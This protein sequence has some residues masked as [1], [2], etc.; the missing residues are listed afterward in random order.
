MP[1]YLLAVWYDAL[2]RFLVYTN[3]PQSDAIDW[4]VILFVFLGVAA[5]I[6][7]VRR[8]I[9]LQREVVARRKAQAEAH[10]MARHDVLTGLPNRRRF[11]EDFNGSVEHLPPGAACAMFV[12]DLDNF[13]PINDV[14]GHRLGDEVLKVISRRLTELAGGASVARLGGDEFGVTLQYQVGSDAPERLARQIVHELS[15]PIQLAALSLQVGASVGVATCDKRGSGDTDLAGMSVR[16]NGAV[17]T[18]LRRADMAMYWAKADGRGRYRFFDRSMD[19]KLRQ[20]VELELQIGGA[21]TLGQIV[22]YYQ[23]IV[24]LETG[25]TIG[26]EVLARWV[27][28]RRGVLTSDVFIAIAEDTGTI[29]KMTDLLIERAM[30]DAKDWPEHLSVSVNFSPRQISDPNVATRILGLL[31]KVGFP[32]HR[33]VMEITE[34]AVVQKLEAAKA[35]LQSLRNVGVRIALD[36][37]GTGYSGLYHLRE[38]ELDIVKIDRSFVGEIL[39][40]PEE[41]RIVKAMLSLGHALG[42]TTTAEGIE[43]EEV[44]QYLL[45]LGCDAGQGYL[46]GA[47]EPAAMVTSASQGGHSRPPHRLA[48]REHHHHLPAFEPRLRFHLG[49]SRG[50]L[51]DPLEQLG[52]ELHMRHLAAPEAQGDFHLVALLEEP[53]DR[54]HLHLVVVDVDVRPHLDLLDLDGALLLARLGGLFLRL[55]FVLAVIQDLAHRRL[56]IGRDLDQIEPGFNRARQGFGRGN[57]ADIVAGSVDE[58]D[59]GNVDALV[60]AR[61]ALFGGK[62]RRPSYDVSFSSV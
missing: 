33:L 46:F 47:P 19:E 10:Q 62:L 36:D 27:H 23:R 6:Y 5:K 29:G 43:T 61:A 8:T 30:R 1:L 13:K 56:G 12:L 24:R 48:G 37:F 31:T 35:V 54:A 25:E 11:I 3:E 40:K 38:L 7:S 17:E 20:R 16:D 26:F 45:K 2:D 34:G 60:D 28:P 52:A 4:L 51:L 9:D 59:V 55:V 39:N 18:M 21:I 53:P 44:R 41:A 49:D 50:V 57:H 15:R 32:P 14:Y 58:L 42:L 22:P